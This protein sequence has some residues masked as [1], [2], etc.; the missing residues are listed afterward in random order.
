M[1][2]DIPKYQKVCIICKADNNLMEKGIKF[3]I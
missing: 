3:F 1:I 2:V